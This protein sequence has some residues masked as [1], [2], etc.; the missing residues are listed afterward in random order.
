MA[1][2]DLF[3]VQL[4]GVDDAGL[5]TGKVRIGFWDSQIS[6]RSNIEVPVFLQSNLDLSFRELRE[7]AKSQALELLQR[8]AQLLETNTTDQLHEAALE[9]VR[10]WD[11]EQEAQMK[12]S[13][14]SSFSVEKREG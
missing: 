13:I 8:A 6:E 5:L 14:A 10:R 2:F 9:A 11:A 4:A 7:E 1:D 3:Q 12:E